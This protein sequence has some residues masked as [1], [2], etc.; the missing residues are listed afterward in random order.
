MNKLHRQTLQ[1]HR[2]PEKSKI[3]DTVFRLAAPDPQGAGGPRCEVHADSGKQGPRRARSPRYWPIGPRKLR[4][5]RTK[6][7]ARRPRPLIDR[8]G[9]RARTMARAPRRVPPYARPANRGGVR[10]AASRNE[11]REAEPQVEYPVMIAQEL[12]RVADYISRLKNEIGA[13]RANELY[14]IGF[15]EPMTNWATLSTPPPRQRIPSWKQPRR[16]SA[17]TMPISRPTVP[18]SDPA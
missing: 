16:F 18:G 10:V 7:A 15:P 17:T 11:G 2:P 6:H 5:P 4:V 13:L 1:T 8:D 9:K 12:T 14:A 3:E